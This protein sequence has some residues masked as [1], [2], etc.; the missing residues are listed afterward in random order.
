MN[1]LYFSCHAILE[2]DELKIFEELGINYFSLG[3]YVNPRQPVD[4]IRPALNHV[5]DEWL[6]HHAPDRRNIPQ[7]FID[8]FD[9]IVIMD[10]PG[11]ENW[12]P[13]NWDK[14]K[15]KIVIWRSIGQSNTKHEQQLWEYRQKGLKI[16]R[17]SFREANVE[18]TIGSDKVIRFYKDPNEFNLWNGV[19]KEVITFAQDMKTRAE[20][21]NYDTFL[22]IVDGFNAKIYGPK[23]QSSAD[24]NGGFL[25]YDALRQK[26]RDSRVYIYTGTQPASYTL[27]FIEAWMTGIPVVA[28]GPEHGNSL[29]IAGETYE[30]QDYIQN[31]VNGFVSDDIDY[32]RKV[33]KLLLDDQVLAKRIGDMGRQS[34]IKLFSKDIIKQQW[35]NFLQIKT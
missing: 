29:K 27:N 25:T 2:Y 8:K 26:M 16:V 18:G 33:T 3:S 32:L 34:A 4:P 17:Y 24:L 35:A 9:I 11:H 19:N 12:I 1:L 14:F 22:K 20:Y 6:Y 13:I 5:P 23:N 31:G 21:C 15:G 28:I 30:I 10:Y 7:E